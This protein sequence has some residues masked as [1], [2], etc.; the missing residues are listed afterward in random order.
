MLVYVNMTACQDPL[1]HSTVLQRDSLVSS[2]QPVIRPM[3]A[4]VKRQNGG[5]GN[6][7]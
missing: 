2:H 7:V 6:L 1:G 3:L 5:A 4:A